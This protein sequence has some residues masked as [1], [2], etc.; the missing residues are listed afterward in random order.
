MNLCLSL[1]WSD[2]E[3]SSESE[4]DCNPTKFYQI[5][6]HYFSR[7]MANFD[8]MRVRGVNN[9]IGEHTLWTMNIH[10]KFSCCQN[11]ILWK[12]SS[13]SIEESSGSFFSA[14]QIHPNTLIDM[15]DNR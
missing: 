7:S 4:S 3:Q 9:I 12:E 15:W 2:T 11:I 1:P 10:S 8:L 13:G 6:I 5:D 14:A